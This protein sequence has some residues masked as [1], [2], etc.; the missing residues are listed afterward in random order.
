MKKLPKIEFVDGP[1]GCY[2]QYYK[3]ALFRISEYKGVFW[4]FCP[5]SFQHIYFTTEFG[6]KPKSDDDCYFVLVAHG[7]ISLFIQELIKWKQRDA[8]EQLQ[9]K[10]R[11]L[12]GI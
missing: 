2:N 11:D 3:S 1:S 5:F 12:L 4:L 10:L 8:Q 7:S 9:K 6:C